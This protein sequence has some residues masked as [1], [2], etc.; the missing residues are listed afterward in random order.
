MVALLFIRLA[1]INGLKKLSRVKND[2]DQIKNIKKNWVF[3][4]KND[5]VHE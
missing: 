4:E 5:N 2:I 1:K 3:W